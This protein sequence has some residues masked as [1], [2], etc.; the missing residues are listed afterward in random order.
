MT[1][2]HNVIT[3]PD[4]HEPKGVAAASSGQVYVAN[5]SGSGAWKDK[6][7][8]LGVY[9]GFDA[10]TPAYSHATTT[11]DTVLNNTWVTGPNDGFT[12]L[13]VPNTRLRYDG[14]ETITTFI[15]VT[16]STQQ[17]SGSNKDVE[18]VIYKNGSPITGSRVVR[19]LTTGAWGSI[20]FAPVT[21]LATNDYLEIFTKADGAATVLYSSIQLMIQGHS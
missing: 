2:Q 8:W 20:T 5:G 13:T 10:V 14:T 4:I 11:S 18:W 1:I 7:K 19:T 17:A 15:Q 3:D 16:V 6:D 21:T 9:T 12:V